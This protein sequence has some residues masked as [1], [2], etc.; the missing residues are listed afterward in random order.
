MIKNLYKYF[1]LL[2][3]NF[4]MYVY[5]RIKNKVIIKKESKRERIGGEIKEKN[6]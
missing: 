4:E 6:E 1:Y 5:E 2:L 3:F